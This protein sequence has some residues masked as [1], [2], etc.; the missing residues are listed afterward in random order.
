MLAVLGDDGTGTCQTDEFH[1][2][3]TS[4]DFTP[5]GD[6]LIIYLNNT[7]G[8][9]S[10]HRIYGFYY[11]PE[12]PTGGTNY[13]PLITTQ[14][15]YQTYT[16]FTTMPSGQG[17]MNFENFKPNSGNKSS[18]D[19][20]GFENWLWFFYDYDQ[21]IASTKTTLFN[22]TKWLWT[23]V[24]IRG[25]RMDAVKH[26]TPEFVGDLLDDLHS[27]GIDPGLVVGEFYDGNSAALKSWIDGVYSY[28]DAATKSA[29]MPRVFDFSLRSAL[30]EACDNSSYDVR[31]VFNSSIVDAQPGTNG[32]NVVTFVG[33]H[34]FRETG[35]YIQNDLILAYAYI[36]TN[37]Q[38]GLPCIFY[39]DYYS[40]S[41][42]PNAGKVRLMHLLMSISSTF[43]APHHA[44][45]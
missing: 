30:K 41:G 12:G 23:S 17:A 27:N 10:D 28:M 33:N 31:N 11:D 13:D 25:L 9:Y 6:K 32:F 36:L 14:F 39:P 3:L 45:I 42:F 34:D 5:S 35:Q 2:N 8:T 37:N 7:S 40:V 15:N 18:T 4:S 43:M 44:N 24:G 38:I 21:N 20:G 1:L 16:D 29:I 22:W 26:F 19:L